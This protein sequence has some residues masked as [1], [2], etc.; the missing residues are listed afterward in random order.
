MTE[1]SLK[2][3]AAVRAVDR[4]TDWTGTAISWLSVPLVGAVAYEVV[5]R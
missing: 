4:F 2:L 1:P 5:A 3:L